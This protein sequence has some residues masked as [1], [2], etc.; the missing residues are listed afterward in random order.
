MYDQEKAA[1]FAEQYPEFPHPLS[2]ATYAGRV[3][4]EHP[5]MKCYNGGSISIKLSE[6][7]IVGDRCERLYV[8][9][10]DAELSSLTP[11]TLTVLELAPLRKLSGLDR[12]DHEELVNQLRI[13]R[14]R[15][16]APAPPLAAMIH[17][18]LPYPCVMHALPLSIGALSLL[19]EARST[20]SSALGEK[21][22]FLRSRRDTL[23]LAKE[24]AGICSDNADIEATV[25]EHGGLI[26]FGESAQEACLRML[27]LA[28][29]AG[30]HVREQLGDTAST[31]ATD[32]QGMPADL[33]T[34]ATR[35][36]GVIRGTYAQKEG[37]RYAHIRS[38]RALRT[39]LGETDPATLCEPEGVAADSMEFPVPGCIVLENAPEQE[40]ALR[41]TVSESLASWTTEP[42]EHREQLPP[43]FVVKAVG[44]IALGTTVRQA[45]RTAAVVEHSLRS[46]H[47]AQRLGGRESAGTR[48]R[49]G[50]PGVA[51]DGAPVESTGPCPV[52]GQVALITGCGGAIGYGIADRVLSAGGA[53]AIADVDAQRLEKVRSILAERHGEERVEALVF[54]VTDY[55]AVENAVR[56]TCLRLGGLDLLVPN[57][58]IAHV[59]KLECLDSDKFRKVIEVNLMGTFHVVKAVTPV[60]RRQGTGGNV[61]LVSSK[62]VPDPGASFGAYSASKAAA[63][64]IGKIAALELAELGVRVNMLNPDAVFGDEQV[65]SGLWDLIGPDRMKSR[66]LDPEGLREYYRKR[67]LLK[68]SVLAEHVGNA[69]VFFAGN[70]IPTT[71]ASLP[72]DGGVPGAFPR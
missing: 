10:Q 52:T 65:S 53:V 47:L 35:L 17:A 18:L 27:R 34:T 60:F 54:D 8:T 15:A 7:D 30:S 55:G 38:S 29:S 23:Q 48:T 5:E 68:A 26:T 41:N 20:I 24:V 45:H 28:Q 19:K 72:I 70:Q 1:V 64:Q 58:G 63:H 71:G 36:L 59:A 46:K 3:I 61:V 2:Q 16:D 25:V 22:A 49:S 66:G 40:D 69:V 31:A 67:N 51:A 33:E 6:N 56:Q 11:H 21:V 39:M 32:D 12:I 4:A 9:A 13:H 14:T 43:V 57:A 50:A 42:T 37:L 62:N 44:L